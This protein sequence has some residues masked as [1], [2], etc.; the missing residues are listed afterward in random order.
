VRCWVSDGLVSCGVEF[1]ET[2][3]AEVPPPH[4]FPFAAHRP[5]Y[6]RRMRWSCSLLQLKN[7]RSQR[8]GVGLLGN[9]QRGM[10]FH[11]HKSERP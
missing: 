7:W 1:L 10:Q 4:F 11:R 9:S 8:T 5:I 3:V 2:K 6:T